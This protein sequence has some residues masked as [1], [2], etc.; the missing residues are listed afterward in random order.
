VLYKSR[1]E[2]V[3]GELARTEGSREKSALIEQGL[4][5]YKAG[6]VELSIFK[7]HACH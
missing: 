2:T 4:K 3:L 6:S 7:A 5:R 1:L